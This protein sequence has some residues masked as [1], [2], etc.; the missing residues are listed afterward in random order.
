MAPLDPLIVTADL[1][2]VIHWAVVLFVVLGQLVFAIGAGLIRV[3]RVH[4]D[5]PGW[6]GRLVRVTRDPRVRFAHLA[7][8]GYI[9]I[10][11]WLGNL[12]FLTVWEH[13]LRARAGQTIDE[14][15]GF[16]A[17]FLADALYI[18]AP[19]QAFVV[20]YTLFFALVLATWW[21][22]PPRSRKAHATA[23]VA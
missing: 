21:L 22:A 5:A 19:W 23:P 10:N 18:D 13:A 2:V 8:M 12:C 16:I 17:G 14:G 20:V 6:R 11:T 3:G 7:T 15:T 4:G 1:L 9:V